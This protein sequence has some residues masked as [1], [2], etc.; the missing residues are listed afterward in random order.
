MSLLTI[1]PEE[2][3]RRDMHHYMLAA[4]APRPICFA[5]TISADGDVN[6]SPYSFFNAF[7]SNPPLMVFSAA[8][9]GRDNQ[10]KHTLLNAKET[11]EVVINVVTY[12]MVEQMSLASTAYPKGVNEF[13]KAGLT[14]VDSTMVKPPRVAEAPV[15]FE[16]VVE[17]IKELGDWPGAGN[18]IFA[19]V[20]LMHINQDYLGEDGM[21]DTTKLDLVGRM[22][23]EWYNRTTPDALFSIPKPTRHHGIGIDALPAYIKT[24]ESFTGNELARMGGLSS[25]PN[26]GIME[27]VKSDIL[28][29]LLDLELQEQ[30]LQ[31]VSLAKTL[32]EEGQTDESLALLLLSENILNPS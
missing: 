18:L 17:E 15:S 30:R 3:S 7:S 31:V 1:N 4:V 29:Q 12:R 25:F 14:A 21:L 6:L 11:K 32:L 2:I 24:S 9:G 27:Q 22:G 23:G 13:V 5:S 16:C 26:E 20:V 28:D 8:R 10:L 19:R